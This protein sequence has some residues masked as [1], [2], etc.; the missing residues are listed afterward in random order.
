MLSQVATVTAKPAQG[1][2][3]IGVH[4]SGVR[5]PARP[6]YGHVAACRMSSLRSASVVIE[7]DDA[8]AAP[9]HRE[10]LPERQ[11]R[12]LLLGS[13]WRDSTDIVTVVIG[14]TPV[15]P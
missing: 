1:G 8:N 13:E 4:R 7:Q 10:E 12:K 14:A 5:P 6:R 2:P 9:P 11:R 15:A 3:V